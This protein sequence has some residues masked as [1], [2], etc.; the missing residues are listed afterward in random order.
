MLAIRSRS[1]FMIASKLAPT[2]KANPLAGEARSK[3]RHAP[4]RRSQL[5]GDPQPLGA[6]DREHA[7]SYK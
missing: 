1:V 5:A 6:H 2:K 3:H 4:D 7:R